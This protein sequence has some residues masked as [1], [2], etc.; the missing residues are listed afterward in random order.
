MN[1][2]TGGEYSFARLREFVRGSPRGIVMVF[3]LETNGLYPADSVLSCTAEKYALEA[4]ALRKIGFFNR[5]Y[6]PR[7]AEN[8]GAVRVNGL[9]RDVISRKREGKDWPEHFLDDWDFIGFCRDVSMV[10]AHNLE[11]D[12]QFCPFLTG[13]EKFCTMKSHGAGKYP[14]L[15]ELA[16]RYG[17]EADSGSLHSG[18]YDTALASEVLRKILEDLDV[19]VFVE[20]RYR[21][22]RAGEAAETAGDYSAGSAPPA[23][24]EFS[25]ET[26]PSGPDPEKI[27]TVRRRLGLL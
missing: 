12:I 17:I 16:R 10:A 21:I 26:G 13:K 24:G 6:H 23:G 3:D 7:E 4:G 1:S 18:E 11:F 9:T 22:P 14:R 27:K 20:S 25:L 19:Y 8:P 15:S 2:A 5:F